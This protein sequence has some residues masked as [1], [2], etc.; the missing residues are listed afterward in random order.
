MR[1]LMVVS[2]Q[3]EDV[4][5]LATRA[6]LI[7][8]GIH[9]DLGT[10]EDTL[11]IHAAYGTQFNADFFIKD[12]TVSS[13]D[14]LIIPGGKYVALTVDKD[15]S[16]KKLARMFFNQ[17]KYLFAICAGPRFLLQEDLI[18]DPFTAFPGSEIDQTNGTYLPHEKVVTNDRLITARSVGAVYDFVFA[19]ILKLQGEEAL[20]QFKKSILY[21]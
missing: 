8:A 11:A 10:F 21:A 1:L 15:R 6:L 9:V 12:T 3:N 4:E 7:R 17:N 14:G 16:I 18:D 2:H 19:I 20:N 5:T 13:Y